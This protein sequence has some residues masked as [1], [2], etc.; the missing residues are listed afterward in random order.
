MTGS[1]PIYIACNIRF[2]F[3]I[4][5]FLSDY[6]KHTLKPYFT[7]ILFCTLRITPKKNS[8]IDMEIYCTKKNYLRYEGYCT[9]KL[10]PNDV[11]CTLLFHILGMYCHY[12]L[13]LNII[14]GISITDIWFK[15][16]LCS[17]LYTY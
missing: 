5:F 14:T 8:I 6:P 3:V 11:Y 17:V 10:S 15:F 4:V 2:Y 16:V 12:L 9:K 1:I 7:R 13:V